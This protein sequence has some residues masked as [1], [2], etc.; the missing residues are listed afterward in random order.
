MELLKPLVELG[1][2]FVWAVYLLGLLR[3]Q[4]YDGNLTFDLF[5]ARVGGATA[6]HATTYLIFL[7]IFPIA[8][9][10]LR[11]AIPAFLIEVLAF[12]MHEGLWQIP[13]Y[14]AWHSTVDWR[15]WVVE[16]APDTLTTFATIA[17]LV[18]VYHFPARFFVVVT[19]AWGC[20]LS[21]W[22]ALG[23]PVSVLSKLPNYQVVPSI[24]NAVLWV[25]QIEFLGWLYFAVVLLVCLQRLTARAPK[26]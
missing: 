15:V 16:N 2:V 10:M 17:V 12:E 26:K 14:I 1:L 5:L 11:S 6:S 22:L 9:V 4:D 23:F 24:Y 18:L 21:A 13:Y 20:F 8:Y 3:S 7:S 25:N 19:V